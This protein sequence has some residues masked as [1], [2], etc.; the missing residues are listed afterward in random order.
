MRYAQISPVGLLLL[1]AVSLVLPSCSGE[2]A[3]PTSSG[4][5]VTV[6]VPLEREVIDYADFMG[7]V[8]AVDS[9][10]V[11]A[12]VGGYLTRINFSD[13]AVVSRGD[14][15]FEIDR[16]TYQA[17]LDQALAQVKVAEAQLNFE[18][19]DLSRNLYLARTGAAS[20]QDV[21]RSE[22]SRDVAAASVDKAKAD[23]ERRRLDVD[24]TRVTAPVTGRIGRTQYAVGNLIQG[25]PIGATQLATIVSLDPVYVYFDVDENTVLKV[26]QLIREHKLQYSRGELLD[27]AFQATGPIGLLSSP[28]YAPLLAA[29]TIFPD[30]RF[31]FYPAF[32][33][34]VSEK[35]Y[36]HEGYLDFV[37]NQLDPSTGTLRVRGVFTNHKQVLTSGLFVRVRVPLS[38][39]HKVLLVSDKAIG[40]VLDQ[41]VV[42]VV[43]EK[44]EIGSR[45]VR[46]GPMHEGLREIESGLRPGER[47]VIGG[48]QRVRPGMTVTPK[49]G[50]MKAPEAENE[51]E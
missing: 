34:L 32:L 6:A 23:A 18:N 39:K 33:G 46:L 19:A 17:E 41:K 15:L 38:N 31:S 45:P 36:P 10:D 40:T 3:R 49:E 1:F 26:Q 28:G 47:V 21:D 11:R 29:T 51:G 35:D 24:F 2:A 7:R 42:F 30:K 4:T 13:G 44:N 5:A 50:E 48:L 20:Q 8:A 16:R 25:G 37:N 43:N 12:M 14:L 22:R 9:V 27:G